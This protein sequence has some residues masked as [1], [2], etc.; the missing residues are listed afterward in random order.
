MPPIE[1]EQNESGASVPRD[2]LLKS[3]YRFT[4]PSQTQVSKAFQVAHEIS[5]AFYLGDG[6]WAGKPSIPLIRFT[7]RRV[8]GYIAAYRVLGDHVYLMRAREGL[9]Y[10]LREQKPSGT[11]VWYYRS[12]RGIDN[13]D[14]GLY[15]TAIAG[16]ALLE[17][18]R[19]LGDNRY[20][21]ASEKAATWAM[22]CPISWNTNYNMFAVWHL[23]ALYR[24]TQKPAYL[25]AA[26]YKTK[27]GGMQG[28]FNSGG[29]PGHNSWSWYHGIIVRGMAELYNVL[30][31]D[32]PFRVELQPSLTAAINRLIREQD[33]TGHIPANPGIADDHHRM[34]HPLH[35]LLL[36]RESFGAALDDCIC[37]IEQFRIATEPT[38]LEVKEFKRARE[39]WTRETAEARRHMKNDRIWFDAFDQFDKDPLW[40]DVAKGWFNC[41]YPLNDPMPGHVLWVRNQRSQR[42][43]NSCLEYTC[44][45]PRVFSGIGFRVP[46]DLLIPGDSYRFEVWV[47]CKESGAAKG[48]IDLVYISAYSGQF[49]DGWDCLT[50]CAIMNEEPSFD[51]YGK[52]SVRF[53]AQPDTTYLYVYLRADS[54]PN[55]ET[56]SMFL[57]E[58]ELFHEG[59]PLPQWKSPLKY[60][61]WDCDVMV[62]GV[63]LERMF[64]RGDADRSPAL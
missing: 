44:T 10:L 31:P 20:L 63:Y 64:R 54:V 37:G 12:I 50:N 19:L 16:C 60:D 30:P 55:G 39:Q 42:S 7:S 47:K 14:D 59:K 40:G 53:T 61:D 28:Q 62:T 48:C 2:Y 15:E 46:K 52:L 25:E 57:D 35:G 9:E 4:A 8:I 58:A 22:N 34:S 49:R 5:E 21:I 32:H 41:W 24:E 11:F 27:E 23:A 17:G 43:G 26:V 36:A 3:R 6:I 13:Q 18:Y 51:D 45:G 33:I 1:F 56:V 29:W 38:L